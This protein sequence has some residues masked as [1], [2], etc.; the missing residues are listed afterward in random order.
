MGACAMYEGSTD[1]NKLDLASDESK[2]TQLARCGKSRSKRLFDITL[3]LFIII[4]LSPAFILISV[5]IKL[6]SKGPV[7]FR[8]RRYGFNRKFFYI[9]KFRSM[10]V[11]EDGS[12]IIQAQTNDQRVTRFGKILR[13]TSL[14]ELPQL[15]N[16]LKGEMSF[17]GPRPHALAH[18]EAFSKLIS[19]YNDR[20]LAKPG[21]TGLAQITGFRGEIK[22]PSDIESRVSADLTYIKNWS[23]WRDFVI[24]SMTIPVI[25]GDKKAY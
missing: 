2:G 20:F 9:L 4:F 21:L 3:S 18:D 22:T 16:I 15:I 10:S 11:T 13:R 12:T 14:D 23:L 8:Q 17:V 1:L 19:N 24:F 25:F 5:I 7:F 6:D